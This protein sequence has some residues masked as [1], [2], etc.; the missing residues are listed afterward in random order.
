MLAT[1]LGPKAAEVV[2]ALA[3]RDVRVDFRG[4][5]LLTV[6]SAT[7]IDVGQLRHTL[8]PLGFADA[9]IQESSQAGKNYVT[10]RTPLNTSDKSRLEIQ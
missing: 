3:R 1:F 2:E 8:E 10:I 4:G 9:S 7:P 6:S 5:D